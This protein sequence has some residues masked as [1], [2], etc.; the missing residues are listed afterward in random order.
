MSARFGK[1]QRSVFCF[2]FKVGV[3]VHACVCARAH[4]NCVRACVFLC[5]CVESI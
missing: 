3:C 5:E 1:V 4:S 2:C